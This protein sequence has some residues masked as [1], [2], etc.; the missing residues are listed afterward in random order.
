MSKRL[1][2]IVPSFPKLSETFILSKFLGLLERGWD[3]HMVCGIS[4]KAQYRHFPN[5]E[6][7]PWARRRIR[8]AWPHRPRWLA[9]L[10]LPFSFLHCLWS[11]PVGTWRYLRWGARRFGWGVLRRFFLDANLLALNPDLI[12]FE[13]G[14]LAAGRMYLRRLLG[15]KIVVSFRGYD[16]NSIGLE[17]SDYYREVWEEASALHFL[18]T[19][20]WRRA[21]RRGC[22]P[23]KPHTLIPPAIDGAFFNPGARAHNGILGTIQRPLRILSVGRLQWKKGYEYAL[24]AAGRLVENGVRCQ[25]RIVGDG[26]YLEPVAF[27][28]HQL[29]LKDTVKLLGAQTQMEIREQMLWADVFLHSAVSEGFC[30]AVLEAQAMGLPIVCSDAGGLPGNVADGESGFVVPRRDAPALAEKLAVLSRDPILRQKMGEAG[31][32]RVLKQFQL[33]DQIEA[34]DRL[35]RSV[36]SDDSAKAKE[37][38]AKKAEEVV[39]ELGS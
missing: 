39:L 30:N 3:V 19:D 2:L 5:L 13:F 9:G 38:P 21:Q 29:G 11:N 10:L 33:T 22:P 8:V 26:K 18:G 6:N 20:L 35:Y 17:S 31:R 7:H 28:R 4:E 23:D 24:A 32:C 16:L 1:V 14:T 27:A 12:H 25:Y 34:Y 15:R 37:W 36:L